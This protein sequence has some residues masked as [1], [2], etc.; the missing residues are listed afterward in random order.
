MTDDELPGWDYDPPEGLSAIQAI[1]GEMAA[2][3]VGNDP[4]FRNA[5][6]AFCDD[7]DHD[8]DW[9]LA[10]LEVIVLLGDGLL[11]SQGQALAHSRLQGSVARQNS[12]SRR[13]SDDHTDRPDG[14]EQLEQPDPGILALRYLPES[15]QNA[16]DANIQRLRYIGRA[17]GPGR[18]HRPS[19]SRHLGHGRC[20]ESRD[21]GHVQITEYLGPA[22]AGA[23]GRIIHIMTEPIEQLEQLGIRRRLRA[24]DPWRSAQASSTPAC[25]RV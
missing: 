5:F 23:R 7:R 10:F 1:V 11:A 6:R 25:G 9:R 21:R 8:H 16:E 3:Y 14:V 18:R 19:G 2:M 17:R 13:S 12:P 22:L 24:D 4:R 20:R 15:V